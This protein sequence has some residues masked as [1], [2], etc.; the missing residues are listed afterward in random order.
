ME[1]KKVAALGMAATMTVALAACGDTAETNA[2]DSTSKSSASSSSAENGDLISY[3]D[4]K[5]GEDYTD[6]KATIKLFSNRTD[7]LDTDYPG[8]NWDAYIKEFNKVYPNIEVK[9]DASTNYNED[10]LLRLQGGDWGDIMMIP[11]VD[12]S[13]LGSYFLSYGDLSAM[14]KQVNYATR[15]AYDDQVYGIASTAV[16]RGVVY[17]KKVFQEA[18]VT[19]LPKTQEEF[20]SALQAIKDKTD[21]IPLYTN[22]AAGWT[23]GAWDDYITGNATADT[24]YRNQT[25]LHTKAPF[26]DLG[27]GTH[28]YNVYKIL[29]DAVANGLTEDD[30]TTTDW[31]GSKGMLN[32]GE[33]GC[34]VLGSWAYPQMQQAGPNSD[35]IGYM[36]FPMTIDGK[37]YSSATPDYCYG[38]NKDADSDNQKAAMAFVKWMTEESGFSYNEGGL[39]IKVGDETYPEVYQSFIDNDVTFIPD[40]PAAKGEEDLL[41]TLNADSEL[42]VGDSGNEKIQSL[43]EHAANKDQTF[44]EIM[45]EWNQKWSG[46]QEANSVEAQ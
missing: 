21:A 41:N 8:T 17:N 3:A 12:F 40:A 1:W 13:E 2:G 45:D 20:R 26:A 10:S 15:W 11:A 38:I 36:V 44:D 35:D 5:L 32:K 42:M 23:M 46:A 22:Y 6:L 33:I 9:V 25:F 43:I 39:P 4:L 24:N 7:M 27:D 29:Y 19:E 14:E 30:Y 37:Q 18:G 34:M 31:E 16:G 28:A